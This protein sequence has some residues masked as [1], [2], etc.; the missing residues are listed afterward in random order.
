MRCNLL[1]SRSAAW[2][3][4]NQRAARR[5]GTRVSE[6]LYHGDCLEVLRTLEAESVDAV[7]T[8]P[9]YDLTQG[10][11]GGSGDAS[12]NP[13]SPAG[14]SRIGTGGGFM[15]LHWDATGIAFEPE[16][17]VA[18]SRVLK[19]GAHVLA[20][21]GTRTYHRMALAIEDAGFEIR[22]CLAWL[23]GSGFPKSL[24]LG[25]GL[26]TALK[27]A[28]EPIVL[29][30]KPFKGSVKGNVEKHGTGALNIDACRLAPM[31][32][33]DPSRRGLGYG[34]T[35]PGADP[36]GMYSPGTVQEYDD[37][38]GRWPANVV[39]DDLAAMVLDEMSGDLG[40]SS[41]GRIGNAGG[42]EYRYVPTGISLKG[43]PGYGDSGG[44][45]RFFYVAK[46]SREERDMGC[47]DLPARSG[48]E[49]TA[50]TDGT[51]GLENPRA[52]AG[53]TGGARNYHPTV[54][55]VELMRWLVR[56]VTPVGGT[57][58]DPFL[59][60]GTTGMA[61]RYELRNFI[62]IEKEAEYLEIAK[63]R[64]AAVAPLFGTSEVDGAA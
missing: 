61:C 39:L 53:R 1:V 17:W 57:V 55:P 7:V 15:G 59:G 48:G 9:P 42:T 64:I 14:R 3:I 54:K 10:K 33:D 23:Y 36:T 11:R 37:S 6:R 24:N 40:E 27:P 22:D 5:G 34:F 19:P 51:A 43:N 4:N 45:S 16:T 28:Y 38:K 50:R 47:Y 20:C 49:A 41:G 62:G 46:P 26:G 52:G 31:A 58:I 30:R 44:A 32:P 35:K 21:G 8:D 29:A 60:S 25:E 13:N 63:R 12:M 2:S 18:V 56:L